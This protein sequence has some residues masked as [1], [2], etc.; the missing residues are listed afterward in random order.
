M[1][2]HTSNAGL[3]EALLVAVRKCAQAPRKFERATDSMVFKQASPAEMA[4][5]RDVGP[6]S[7]F[8]SMDLNRR[9]QY[10]ECIRLVLRMQGRACAESLVREAESTILEA[11]AQR[12]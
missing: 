11:S 12:Q 8:V 9:S 10:A 5:C 3:C 2:A 4:L 7:A 6:E 1:G